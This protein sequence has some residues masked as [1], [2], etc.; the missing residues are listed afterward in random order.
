MGLLGKVLKASIKGD[1][2]NTCPVC[3]GTLVFQDYKT[4]GIFNVSKYECQSC[5]N[6]VQKRV[7]E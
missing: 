5:G 6:I 7:A 4:Q 1:E 3:G 2:E